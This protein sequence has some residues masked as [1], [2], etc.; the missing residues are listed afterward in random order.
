MR[1]SNQR[2]SAIWQRSTVV[3][4]DDEPTLELMPSLNHRLDVSIS[5]YLEELDI[6]GFFSRVCHVS[7]Y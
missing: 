7:A 1:H 4:E 6:D 2:I 3:L 5:D